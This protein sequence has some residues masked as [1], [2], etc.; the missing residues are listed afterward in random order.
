MLWLTAALFEQMRARQA[1]ALRE[2]EA[3]AGGRRR[4]AG[5][6]LV[7]ER[8]GGEGGVL[9]NGYGPTENTTFAACNADGGSGQR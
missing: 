5:A 4:A 9:I 2:G 8:L 3:G 6:E 1:E 7:K